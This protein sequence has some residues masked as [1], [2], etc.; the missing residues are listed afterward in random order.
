[1]KS[2]QEIAREITTTFRHWKA[3]HPVTSMDDLATNIA[4]AVSAERARA[5]GLREALE[6]I[7]LLALSGPDDLNGWLRSA[8]EIEILARKALAEAKP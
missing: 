2:P 3:T 4:A 5:D 1:M 7:R 8:D 6:E